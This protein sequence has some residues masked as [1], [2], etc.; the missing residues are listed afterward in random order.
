MNRSAI[1]AR[2]PR[3]PSA[4]PPRGPLIQARLFLTRT[5]LIPCIAGT[6]IAVTLL[7]RAPERY[8]ATI[9]ISVPRPDPPS[10]L[11]R[12][13]WVSA[14]AEIEPFRVFFRSEERMLAALE[15]ATDDAPLRA[16]R[17]AGQIRVES[18]R[19][20]AERIRVDVTLWDTEAGVDKILE[21][22]V[23]WLVQRYER[24]EDFVARQKDRLTEQRTLVSNRIESRLS[25]IE[26]LLAEPLGLE[27]A[28]ALLARVE[29]K[30]WTDAVRESWRRVHG[31]NEESDSMGKEL[32]EL[33]DQIR[34]QRQGLLREQGLLR[35]LDQQ[36]A[37]VD[38]KS[39]FVGPEP[40]RVEGSPETDR[41][42][43]EPHWIGLIAASVGLATGLG[44]IL[45]RLGVSE[46]R[47]IAMRIRRR[48]S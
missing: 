3:R 44:A 19:R 1:V 21:R 26:I 34:R 47:S 23:G 39:R 30:D 20:G 16:R 36:L 22:L 38:G 29:D 48:L 6:A 5:F 13:D 31:S 7:L 27:E 32:V 28:D 14:D 10:A 17:L 8:E 43:R 35:D 41:R 33:R 12:G 15:P 45:L 18:S 24:V 2:D 37:T 40:V 25:D 42:E 46:I 4:I 11:D 9:P